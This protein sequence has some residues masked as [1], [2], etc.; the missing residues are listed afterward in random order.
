MH[1]WTTQSLS[2]E[3]AS[4]VEELARLI[5]VK[6]GRLTRCSKHEAVHKAVTDMIKRLKRK[7]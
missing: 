2:K 5:T 1:D 7:R 6:E 3:T 4:L